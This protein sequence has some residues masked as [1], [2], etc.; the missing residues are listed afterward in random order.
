MLGYHV[1]DRSSMKLREYYHPTHDPEALTPYLNQYLKCLFLAIGGPFYRCP[2]N[3]SSALLFG[4]CFTAPDFS[5]LPN[6]IWQV[7]GL[8]MPAS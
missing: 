8:T 3:Q 2:E 1:K 5:K 4:V 6:V 7:A